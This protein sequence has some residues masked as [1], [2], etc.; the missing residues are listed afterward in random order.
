MKKPQ[1]TTLTYKSVPNV[2]FALYFLD[3]PVIHLQKKSFLFIIHH[4]V[5]AHRPVSL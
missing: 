4:G 3:C 2:F 1:K 5:Y